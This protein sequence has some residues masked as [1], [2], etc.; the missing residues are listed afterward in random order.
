M[1]TRD[2][3][4]GREVSRIQALGANEAQFGAGWYQLHRADLLNM[5]A[6]AL[7]PGIVETNRRCA[8]NL[9]QSWRFDWEP[10][11]AVLRDVWTMVWI[12]GC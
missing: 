2:S 4:T 6:R 12:L 9:Q 10:P 7:P 3:I 11:K 5:L 1:V 8:N